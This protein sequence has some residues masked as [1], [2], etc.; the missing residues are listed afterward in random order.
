[1]FKKSMLFV[2][3]CLFMLLAACSDK[4]SKDSDMIY[5][6][7]G[8]EAPDQEAAEERPFA[9]MVNNHVTARPYTGLADADIVFEILAEGEI[10]RLMALFQSEEPERVGS[11]RSAREYYFDLA[12]RYNA[13]YVYHG[14][15]KFVNQLIQD[16][17]I[18]YVNGALY[19]DDG[20]N[21]IRSTDRKAP[22]NSYVVLSKAKE[23][24]DKLGYDLDI[25]PEPLTFIDEEEAIEDKVATS[26]QITYSSN[27]QY[28]PEYVYDTDTNLYTRTIAGE[29]A[30]DTA[31]EDP[32]TA[33]N[34]FIVEAEHHVFDKEGRREIDLDSG[35]SGYLIQNGQMT[36]V[37]WKN[38]KGQLVPYKDNDELGFV[39]GKTWINVVPTDPG[40]A[41]AVDIG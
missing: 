38:E 30:T 29:E 28:N 16:E 5:P 31:S 13:V 37:E 4:S 3:I 20:E 21:F 24:A 7:T 8:E 18:D 34:I 35:G 41:S 40:L 17:D 2:M 23:T 6:F 12:D 10:T 14:A 36:E 11:V 15:A 27:D 1:M 26:V 19:D 39:R 22:H 25:K 9:V 33:S 32:L